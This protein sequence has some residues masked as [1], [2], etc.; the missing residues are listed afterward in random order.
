MRCWEEFMSL[1][2]HFSSNTKFCDDLF[3]IQSP[4]LAASLSVALY[5]CICWFVSSLSF[6]K[7]NMHLHTRTRATPWDT[8]CSTSPRQLLTSPFRSQAGTGGLCFQKYILKA[9]FRRLVLRMGKDT[10]LG[11]MGDD[12]RLKLCGRSNLKCSWPEE[13]AEGKCHEKL[14]QSAFHFPLC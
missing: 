1:G 9:G 3:S 4:L 14:P 6:S 13:R 11:H 2:R 5:Y 8:S 12:Y 7:C 10:D